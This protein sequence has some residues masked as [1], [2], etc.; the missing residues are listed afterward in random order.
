MD[1]TK[2]IESVI[3]LLVALADAFLIPWLKAKIGAEKF[4]KMVDYVRI[5]VEAAEQI[6]GPEHGQEKKAYVV[7][8]LSARGIEFDEATIDAAIEAAVIEMNNALLK[9]K[10]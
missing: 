8:Y 4:K 5:A 6:I 1:Y 9:E 3:L 7:Q 10:N 2:I